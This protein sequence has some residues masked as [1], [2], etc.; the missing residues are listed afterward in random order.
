[1]KGFTLIELLI[2]IAILAIL[3][4]ATVLVLNP[5]QLLAQARDSQR[6]SDLSNVKSAIGLYLATADSPSM[7][8]SST[9]TVAVCASGVACLVGGAAPGRITASTAVDGTG[10]VVVNLGGTSGG[11]SLGALPLDPSQTAAF[12]YA[13]S[14]VTTSTFK[15]CGVL[16]STKYIPLM[17]SDGGRSDTAYEVGT[18]LAL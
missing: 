14:G 11:S 8:A 12:S 6:I 13:Y 9:C 5:A 17:T 2:V 10:W 4:T 16:E 15:L 1:M 3:A 7:V 18:N